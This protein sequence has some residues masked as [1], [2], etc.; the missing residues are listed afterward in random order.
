MT[1]VLNSDG[2]V[3]SCATRCRTSRPTVRPTSTSL[4]N[5]GL[6]SRVRELETENSRLEVIALTFPSQGE[7]ILPK[8]KSLPE[9]ELSRWVGDSNKVCLNMCPCLVLNIC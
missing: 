8:A 4:V 7:A 9:S 3:R 1:A 6:K 2:S 5:D